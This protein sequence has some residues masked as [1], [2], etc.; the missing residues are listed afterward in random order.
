MRDESCPWV[1]NPVAVDLGIHDSSW[2]STAAIPSSVAGAGSNSDHFYQFLLSC[3]EK[4]IDG[5]LE[6]S[7]LEDCT[8]VIF[9]TEAYTL[10]TVDKVIAALNKQVG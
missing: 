9:G 1:A 3:V 5:E 6:Q 10:F 2:G 8:R 7:A 4:L